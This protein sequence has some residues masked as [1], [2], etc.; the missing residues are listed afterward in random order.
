MGLPRP[1]TLGLVGLLATAVIL[2][3]CSTTSTPQGAPD[4]EAPARS[5]LRPSRC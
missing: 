1:P 4:A 3:S 5:D 2:A